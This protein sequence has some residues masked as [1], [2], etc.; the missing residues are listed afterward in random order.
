MLA[1]ALASQGR[2]DQATEAR[3]RAEGLGDTGFWQRWMYLAYDRR[4]QG[5]LDGARAAADSAWEWV[6]TDIGRAAL[7]SVRVAD[8]GLSSRLEDRSDAEG[9]GNP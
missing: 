9:P 4:R 8:F 3:E 1:W 7:D 5:D 6:A 2:W